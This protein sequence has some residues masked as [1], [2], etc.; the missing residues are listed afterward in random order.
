MDMGPSGETVADNIKRVREARRW[1]YTELSKRLTDL[2]RSVSPLAVRRIEERERRVDVDDLVA[3]AIALEVTPKTLLMPYSESMEDI[4]GITGGVDERA[5]VINAWMTGEAQLP[6]QSGTQWIEFMAL[7]APAWR[8]K[9]IAAV[10]RGVRVV[11]SLDDLRARQTGE[12]P[13][14]R[15]AGQLNGDD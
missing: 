7:A 12:L 6:H 4:V 11:N 10:V 14:P 15:E 8:Y 3:F 13:G 9:E 5:G 2:G 1:T